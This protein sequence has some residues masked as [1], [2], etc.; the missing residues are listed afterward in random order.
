MG[1]VVER[2]GDGAGR[3]ELALALGAPAHVRAQRGDA[4]SGVTVEEQ[5]DLVWE[6]MAI[7][8]GVY[9]VA[10]RLVSVSRAGM[11]G[12]PGPRREVAATSPLRRR[13]VFRCSRARRSSCRARWM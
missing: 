5:V 12:M 8:S 2:Q 6:Q 9:A 7:H 13:Y 4:E 1:E 3:L 10:E 11:P